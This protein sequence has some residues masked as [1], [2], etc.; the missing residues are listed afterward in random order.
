MLDK[1]NDE[2]L[3]IKEQLSIAPEEMNKNVFSY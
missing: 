3:R 2:N 1:I